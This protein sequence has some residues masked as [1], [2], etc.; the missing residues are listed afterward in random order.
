M[1]ELSDAN[2]P[3][4]P[5]GFVP[6]DGYK[7]KRCTFC[8]CWSLSQAPWPLQGTNLDQWHPVLPWAKGTKQKPVADLCKPCLI[9][10]ASDGL[11]MT[12]TIYDL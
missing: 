9:V 4:P 7:V 12:M 1:K 6:P 10:D 11:C 5:E 2:A 3:T 8:Q